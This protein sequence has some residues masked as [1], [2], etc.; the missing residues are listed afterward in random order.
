[1][2]EK[3]RI[4]YQNVRRYWTKANE[5]SKIFHRKTKTSWTLITE[6]WRNTNSIL[7][8]EICDIRCNIFRHDR[9]AAT[10]RKPLGGGVMICIENSCKP[11]ERPEFSRK[12]VKIKSISININIFIKIN[13]TLICFGVAY[14]PGDSEHSYKLSSI[15][16]SLKA[17]TSI[18]MIMLSLKAILIC[19]IYYG[20]AMDFRL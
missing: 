6:S 10:S 3:V 8:K 7:S 15:Y 5:I 16:N 2:N 13:T 1:M 20:Q 9:D 4:Y 14:M 18:S 19:Q 12:G 11:E 17:V